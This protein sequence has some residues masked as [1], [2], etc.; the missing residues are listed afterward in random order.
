MPRSLWVRLGNPTAGAETPINGYLDDMAEDLVD[1]DLGEHHIAVED[2]IEVAAN[3]KILVEGGIESYHF[4]VAHRETIGPFF[5]DN[6]SSYQCFGRNMR[7]I[8]PRSTMA[9]LA[10]KPTDTW[11][12]RDH[13]NVIYTFFPSSQLLVQ[14]D[15]F[16]WIRSTPISPERTELRLATMVPQADLNS[17]EKD[18]IYWRRNH[19]ITMTTLR[20][21][22][23]I[24]EGIQRGLA[25]GAKHAFCI[26]GGF[27]GRAR[28]IQSG[29][30]RLPE[31]VAEPYF[32]FLRVRLVGAGAFIASSSAS[33][34]LACDRAAISAST[35]AGARSSCRSPA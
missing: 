35:S 34:A 24:G 15:H 30:R 7:S 12:L 31:G 25:T 26:S 33:M 11:R 1:L 20:E 28:K 6:L 18:E 19:A 8:L 32:A 9:L 21:D 16:V 14:Q 13:A 5:E 22:F 4:K 2:T 3:W 17:P 27:E 10:D 23:E 29:G